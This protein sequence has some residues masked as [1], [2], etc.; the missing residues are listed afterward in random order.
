MVSA[1]EAMWVHL[2]RFSVDSSPVDR[3]LGQRC[4]VVLVEA[5]L[6]RCMLTLL[7]LAFL[8]SLSNL[9]LNVPS[10]GETIRFLAHARIMVL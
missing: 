3:Q 2:S 4:G 5:D 9:A 10:H 1:G 6:T 8:L 7:D